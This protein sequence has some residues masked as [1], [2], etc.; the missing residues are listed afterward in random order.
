MPAG[1]ME[2]AWRSASDDLGPARIDLLRPLGAGVEAVLV[3]DNVAS[4]P[5][6][7]GVRMATDVTVMEVTEL[8]RAMTFKSAMAG[9]PHGGAKAGIVADPRMPLTEKEQVIRSFARAVGELVD[10]IP[11]PD[12]GTDE[13]CMAWI[14]DEIGRSVGL[15]A[16]LGGIPLDD[17][18]ATGF[19]LAACAETLEQADRLELRGTRVAVQGFGAVGRHAARFLGERGAVLVAASDSRG[20]IASP[21]GLDVESLSEWKTAGHPVNEYRAGHAMERD[22]LV[23][24]DCD[25]LIPAAR[26]NV[27]N[28]ENVGAVRATVVLEGANIPATREAELALHERGVLVV[29]DFVANSG[30]VICAAVE[31]RGG[32]RVD[33]F[34]SIAETIRENMLELLRHPDRPLRDTAEAIAR[35]RV[36]EAVGY[37]VDRPP[38]A[39]LTS[40]ATAPPVARRSPRTA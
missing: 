23:S 28:T 12:M 37:G 17:L 9:I 20:A 14:R 21:E 36:E 22:E 1:A 24:V 33:A 19:G 38:P 40:A 2:A 27:L 34:A 16:V 10:F 18:G 8:A 32:S 3:V 25:V 13:T 5:A 35:R 6:I 30:G 11:G 26:P 31:Y 4:G 15:P 39:I 29:P 7:G